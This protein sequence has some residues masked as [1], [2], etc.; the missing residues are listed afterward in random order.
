M[1]PL[2]PQRPFLYAIVDVAFLRGRAVGKVVAELVRGGTGLLQIRAK[3]TPDALFVEMAREALA[4]ARSG[5][6]PLLVNDRAD[7]ARIVGADGVHV[8]QEDLRPAI[9]RRLLAPGAIIGVSTHSVE[10]V[11]AAGAEPVDY[12]AVGPVFPTRSKKRVDPVVG[13]DLIR[14][15]KQITP[16]PVVAIGGIGPA[17]VG[18]V[19]SAGADGIATIS[20]LSAPADLHMAAAELKAALLASR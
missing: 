20:A 3:E 5:G 10:Q 2:L 17:N 16:F 13:L 9:V 11:E 8:G 18:E 19:V 15:A 14:Q 12:I 6:V 1:S 4:A 7:I